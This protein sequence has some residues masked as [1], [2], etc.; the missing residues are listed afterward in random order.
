MLD[1]YK[2][3]C[4]MLSYLA[5][6]QLNLPKNRI[7]ERFEDMHLFSILSKI[8]EEIDELKKELIETSVTGPN[9][10]VSRIIK[11]SIN[12]EKTFSELGDVAA[13]LVGLTAWLNRYKEDLNN[14][15]A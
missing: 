15:C 12:I 10:K 1:R 8:S 4:K 11:D 14:D 3:E 13:C 9:L 2:N 7:K 6:K 5:Q